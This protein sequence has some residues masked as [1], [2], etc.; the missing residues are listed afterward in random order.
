MKR[1]IV[2]LFIIKT[3]VVIDK[4]NNI[5]IDKIKKIKHEHDEKNADSV[6]NKKD[7]SKKKHHK[8]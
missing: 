4:D 3:N 2:V 1:I 5:I 7:S 6:E 8:K